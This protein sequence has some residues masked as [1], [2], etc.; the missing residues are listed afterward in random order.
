MPPQLE[1]S[2]LHV[3]VRKLQQGI[4]VGG[5]MEILASKIQEL[6]GDRETATG[7]SHAKLNGTPSLIYVII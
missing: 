2:R 7:N 6:L 1:T 4:H 5:Y 3:Y